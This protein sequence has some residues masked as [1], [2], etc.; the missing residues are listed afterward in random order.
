METSYL[1]MNSNFPISVKTPL[2]FPIL[3]APAPF[4]KRGVR[5][6]DWRLWWDGALARSHQSLLCSHK[7][8]LAKWSI[9]L[10]DNAHSRASKHTKACSVISDRFAKHQP[11]LRP[12]A[13]SATLT[14]YLIQYQLNL[15][16]ENKTCRIRANRLVAKDS[17]E[18]ASFSCPKTIKYVVC[19]S[20]AWLFYGTHYLARALRSRAVGAGDMIIKSRQLLTCYKSAHALAFKVL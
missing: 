16:G 3:W 17:H 8:V 7:H 20:G 5:A 13:T 19:L 12:R 14:F 10:R 4:P 2:I 1:R 18:T 15:I 9:H 11:M 6:L